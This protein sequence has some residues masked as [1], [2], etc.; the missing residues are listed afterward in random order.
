MKIRV[1]NFGV[2]VAAAMVASIVSTQ[3]TVALEPKVIN[4][5]AAGPLSNTVAYIE[6]FDG[7]CSAAVLAPT[8]LVTAAHCVAES[9]DLPAASPSDIVIYAPG[10]DVSTSTPAAARVTRIIYDAKRYA[11]EKKGWD[12]AFLVVDQ[13]LG[14][15]PISRLATQ[16]EAS[17]ITANKADLTFVGYGQV[18]PAGTALS[19]AA[20]PRPISSQARTYYWSYD[21]GAGAIDVAINGI[22]GPCYGDSGGPWMYQAGDELLLVGVE[23]LGQGRPCDKTWDEPYEEVPVVSGV[24][25]LVNQ[26]YAAAG[27]AQPAV[28]T[29][30]IKIQ[31]EKQYCAQGRA[32]IY[33]NCWTG[34]RATLQE[35]SA[36]RWTDVVTR[37]APRGYGCKDNFPYG[38]T[39]A[40]FSET[41]ELQRF[42]LVVPKQSGVAR[43]TYDPFVVTRK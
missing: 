30:C 38:L 21:L 25:S 16:E 19:Q 36:N 40:A 3:G 33:Y 10:A 1:C 8:I 39:F 17:A 29:T 14:T 5:T 12:V 43:V 11:D 28:P 7:N 35:L 9:D 26:A 23:S 20:S 42:R 18:N 31:G 32:W 15:T 13:P 34:S 24:K 22:S 41:A 27:I 6:V 37:K 4:G 2:A